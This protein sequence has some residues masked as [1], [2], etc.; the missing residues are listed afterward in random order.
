MKT[1]QYFSDEYLEQCSKA[2]TKQVLTFLEN[3]RLMQNP[4]DKSKLISIKIP[5][6]LLAAFRQQCD[7]NGIKYQTQIKELMVDWL[8]YKPSK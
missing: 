1:I 7:L 6:S 2:S 5:E 8:N 3:Y 4:D